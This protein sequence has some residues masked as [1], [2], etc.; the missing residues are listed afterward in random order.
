MKNREKVKFILTHICK[1][2]IS[3]IIIYAVCILVMGL[4]PVMQ[5]KILESIIDVIVETVNTGV[6]N[7]LI[8]MGIFYIIL[9]GVIF[10]FISMLDNVS[11]F[12]NNMVILKIQYN[13][14]TIIANKMKTLDLYFFDDPHL[15]DLYQNAISNVDISITEMTNFVTFLGTLLVSFGGYVTLIWGFK[16]MVIVV[17]I[18]TMIPMIVLNLCFKKR[19]YK[20]VIKQTLSGRKRNYYF[21]I[22]TKNEYFK[23]QKVYDTYDYF[24][25]KRDTEFNQYYKENLKLH[26]R[27]CIEAFLSNLIG[28]SGAIICMIW[29]M[30]STINGKT[31]IAKFTS[32]FYAIISLQDSFESFFNIISSSYEC[33]LYFNLFFEFYNYES[34]IKSGERK[35]EIKNDN[36]IEFRNVSFKYMGSEKYT[37]NNVSF[38]IKGNGLFMIVGE[39]G[40]GKSTIIKLLLRLYCPESGEIYINGYNIEEYDMNELRKYFSIM[41]QDYNKYALSLKDNITIG[42]YNKESEFDNLIKEEKY[43]DL[44]QIAINLPSKFS[45]QMTKMFDTNGKELSIGQWQRIAIARS[46]YSDGMVWTLDEP[47][48]SVDSISEKEIFDTLN[49]QKD[50]KTIVLITHKLYTVK[51]AKDIIFLEEGRVTAQGTHD[52]LMKKC[53]KYSKLYIQQLDYFIDED[54]EKEE[55]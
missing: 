22:L 13:T 3:M 36:I 34:R 44:N 2:K 1:L 48:A 33:F 26:T 52:E 49:T 28:R 4:A 12:I 51:W 31:N 32:I 23:E 16:K 19:Y 8:K 39:N 37:L 5:L 27:A 11:M 24:L 43:S 6:T 50:E 7:D 45:T 21:D 10:V 42:D 53:E 20:F 14:K 15:L 18:I 46:N 38:K 25:D 9:E 29:L 55:K 30:F 47:T 54:R 41:F 35:I 40:S 17:I